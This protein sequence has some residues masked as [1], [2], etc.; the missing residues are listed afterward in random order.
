MASWEDG[1]EYAPVERPSGYT[2]PAVEPLEMAPPR[3]TPFADVP[4]V[5]PR[6][7][8]VQ[9]DERP[10]SSYEPELGPS[11]DP[12]QPFEVARSTMTEVDSAWGLVHHYHVDAEGW[13]PPSDPAYP[14]PRTPIQVHGAGQ[15][16]AF[17]PTPG[18]D[19]EWLPDSPVQAHWG[20]PETAPTP[21]A[22]TFGAVINAMTVPTFAILLI[23]GLAIAV[24]FFSWLSPLMFIL[25]FA[26][27]TQIAY[28]RHWVRNTFLVA[29]GAL[30]AT[31]VAGALMSGG[32][33]RTLMELVTAV[34]TATCWI[35]LAALM[36]I[37]WQALSNGEQP[38][39][40]A[41]SPPGWD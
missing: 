28:R 14:D 21:R 37:M 9:G 35:V 32:S 33:L 16:A 31:L 24:P 4:M 3:E 7:Y 2:E 34:S 20:S 1:P 5:R 30:G 27:A 36:V 12:G 6:D 8:A 17:A 11:R 22:V 10:L 13:P 23:G 26:T 41:A 19:P 25:A 38:D 15:P 29:S 18:H 40:P 39:P